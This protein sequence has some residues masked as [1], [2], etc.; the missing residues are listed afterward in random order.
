MTGREKGK[1]KMSFN[2]HSGVWPTM[3]TPFKDNGKLDFDGIGK[4]CDWYVRHGCDG[5]FTVCQSSEMRFLSESEKLDLA[6]C[7]AEA[8]DGRIQVIASGHTQSSKSEQYRTIEEMMKTG[9]DAYVLV[10]N[11]LDPYNEGD[12]VFEAN[13]V[14][15]FNRYPEINFG[16]YECPHPY[17]RLVPTAFLKKYAE[18]GE[19]IFLKD[20][21][22]DYELIRERL[23]ATAGTGLKLFNANAATFYDSVV[24][25]GAGYNGIMANF[26]PELY[27][28][29]IAHLKSDAEN[30]KLLA[31][32]LTEAAMIELRLYPV[33]AKYHMV[34]E[35]IDIALES[36]S[37]D[38][39]AF[40]RNARMEVDSL[41][42]LEHKIRRML[43]ITV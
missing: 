24:H 29:V 2:I 28:W 23:A 12:D 35:G 5:V 21:C 37:A 32:F 13:A 18:S 22:C 31:D 15:I 10:S 30:A 39:A 17:K 3:I 14:D 33:S 20:T 38:Q 16:I 19:L 43:G 6:R 34:L 1:S 36:R 8:I 26:H 11:R 7:V 4:M 25:G 42:A 27:K 40:N 41:F 9:V